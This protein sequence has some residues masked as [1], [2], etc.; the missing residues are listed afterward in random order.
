M[1]PS[2]AYTNIK[3]GDLISD[4]IFRLIRLNFSTF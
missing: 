3:N 4:S 1:H 2:V